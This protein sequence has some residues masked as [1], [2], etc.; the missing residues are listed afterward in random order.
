MSDD[1]EEWTFTSVVEE[2][3][4]IIGQIGKVTLVVVG[5]AVV[6]VVWVC[7][8]GTTSTFLLSKKKCR[9]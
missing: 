5:Q 3:K 9:S 6:G 2:V 1:V 8:K 4:T 7:G